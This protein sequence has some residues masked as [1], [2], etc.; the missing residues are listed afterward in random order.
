[1]R[2]RVHDPRVLL[3]HL[4]PQLPAGYRADGRQD[5]G[6]R[7]QYDQTTGGLAS[8]NTVQPRKT[9]NLQVGDTEVE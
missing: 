6:V 7:R 4:T 2:P 5:L 8:A 3:V 1:M 9:K